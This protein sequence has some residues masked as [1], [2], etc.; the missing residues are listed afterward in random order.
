MTVFRLLR[1][2]R[3]L[4]PSNFGDETLLMWI[5]QVENILASDVA[6]VDPAVLPEITEATNATMLVPHP[7]DRVYLPFVQA[8]IAYAQGE[9]DLYQN[10]LALYNAY[11]DEWIAWVRNGK[12]RKSE[13]Y[14]S[15]YALAV[16]HGFTGTIE[17]WLE[18]L[19]G[20][21][22]EKGDGVIIIGHYDTL[23]QLQEAHPT[24]RAGDYYEVG[25]QPDNA[26]VY[27]WAGNLGTWVGI[28]IVDGQW[29]AREAAMMADVNRSLAQQAASSAEKNAATA[30]GAVREA[31]EIESAVRGKAA[32][33]NTSAEAAE[34]AML[35]AQGFKDDAGRWNQSAA[36]WSA[37][38]E[39]SAQRAEAAAR[40]AE[41]GMP[42]VLEQIAELRGNDAQL[43]REI[44]SINNRMQS[45]SDDVS[46][47]GRDYTGL[48]SRVER[49]E[50]K[51]RMAEDMISING[52]DIGHLK[53]RAEQVDG[54]IGELERENKR[55]SRKVLL[56][57]RD[58]TTLKAAAAGKLYTALEESD[59]GDVFVVPGNALP[60]AMIE[61]YTGNVQG[62]RIIGSNQLDVTGIQTYPAYIN[63]NGEWQISNDSA[64]IVFRGRPNTTYTVWVRDG[65]PTSLLR[66]GASKIGSIASGREQLENWTRSFENKRLRIQTGTEA[67]YIVIQ[68]AKTKANLGQFNDLM[69][70]YGDG[71]ETYE[72]YTEEAMLIPY[73][74]RALCNEN[75]KTDL[76]AGVVT[77]LGRQFDIS[78]YIPERFGEITVQPCGAIEVIDGET[79]ATIAYLL[80]TEMGG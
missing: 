25:T 57:Q 32:E 60:G 23:G 75:S 49:N 64:S 45:I 4:S 6:E 22:G 48:Q 40:A 14:V 16:E 37:E 63:N 33:A 7:Y 59:T 44:Q 13:W 79:E 29:K 20:E 9:T 55:L 71:T 78:Q 31:L 80:K 69:V 74:V 26:L 77:K 8:Q 56:N 51:I 47:L 53:G 19:H 52:T 62:F 30:S 61:S 15:A 42:E 72:P 24:G 2:A 66:I 10:Y 54:E 36:E 68:I 12:W 1:L 3:D 73:D 28:D 70:Q 58:I 43:G 41:S 35:A 21:K 39:D 17:E 50:G 34:V 76:R 5:S 27:Y 18:S 11:R 46:E 38:A 67:R 65:D